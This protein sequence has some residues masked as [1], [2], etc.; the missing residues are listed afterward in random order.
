MPRT[1]T[2]LQRELTEHY[3]DAPTAAGILQLDKSHV[4]AQLRAGRFPGAFR[5]GTSRV[6]QWVIPLAA[7][8]AYKET[9]I[10]PADR[11]WGTHPSRNPDARE[12]AP[13]P[14]RNRRNQA[15]K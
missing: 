8:R 2:A 4:C 13:E 14:R 5:F 1:P 6:S 3:C 10:D 12:G 11:R 7:V 9:L 15:R